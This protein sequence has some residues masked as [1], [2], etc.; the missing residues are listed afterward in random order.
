MII[1]DNICAKERELS[2]KGGS[3]ACRHRSV[4]PTILLVLYCRI[5]SGIEGSARKEISEILQTLR[6]RCRAARP[7]DTGCE[8]RS[9]GSRPSL[10]LQAG[11]RQGWTLLAFPGMVKHRERGCPKRASLFDCPRVR[12]IAIL[13]ASLY[14]LYTMRTTE[15]SSAVRYRRKYP[16]IVS[17][18][19]V[20]YWMYA[21]KPNARKIF[22]GLFGNSSSFSILFKREIHLFPHLQNRIN[23]SRIETQ[24]FSDPPEGGGGFD[25]TGD[26]IGVRSGGV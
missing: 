22:Y 4:P 21:D 7:Q 10:C 23:E 1:N 14:N 13:V 20:Y 8:Y 18:Y 25:R 26:W 12:R 24:R 19:C 2:W 6:R 17:V 16:E 11:H 3:G 5:K 15:D 9:G